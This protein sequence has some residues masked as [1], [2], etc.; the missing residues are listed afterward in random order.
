[1]RDYA[2]VSP[3]FWTG[4]TGRRM[5][6]LGLP[7]RVVAMYLLTSPQANALGLYYLPLPYVAHETGLSAA[8]VAGAL[9]GLE[10]IGFCRFDAGSE[11]VWVLEMARYQLGGRLKAADHRVRFVN[12]L[13]RRL[14]DNPFLG[15][16]FE[17][18]A[19]ELCLNERR[20]GEDLEK[21]GEP[22]AGE[23]LRQIAQGASKGL[24]SQETEQE[25]EGGGG[26]ARARSL[27]GREAKDREAAF[28][29]LWAAYPV[30]RGR[31]RAESA[32]RQAW[33]SD[34]ELPDIRELT[35]IVDEF[36]AR[37][38]EWRRGKV[39]RLSRF[40]AEGMWREEPREWPPPEAGGPGGPGDR[41]GGEERR[42][43]AKEL[44]RELTNA[45]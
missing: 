6:G 20:G 9:A 13:Y 24:P 15:A 18:Y 25:Q 14:P 30:R 31:A 8:E 17:R 44:L 7:A 34:P 23:C 28:A 42:E 37:D 32:W 45:E 40:I 33:K 1:V 12:E 35:R 26:R 27:S 2:M 43:L 36:A 11:C 22:A 10:G 21:A 19:E 4:C 16:F 3:G 39:P 5:R 38:V 41:A 29:R